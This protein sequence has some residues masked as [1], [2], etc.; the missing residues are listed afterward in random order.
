MQL[1]ENKES[2]NQLIISVHH[3]LQLHGQ[4]ANSLGSWLGLEVAL[5]TPFLV[6]CELGELASS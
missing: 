1:S 5:N 6:N 4:I 2:V 3:L